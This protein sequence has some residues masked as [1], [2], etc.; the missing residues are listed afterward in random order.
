MEQEPR[1]INF[2]FIGFGHVGR[3]FA[4]L[5]ID[6]KK[7]LLKEYGIDWKITGIATRNHGTAIDHGGLPI[8]KILGSWKRHSNLDNF[9]NGPTCDSPSDFIRQCGADVL[10]EMSVLDLSGEPAA[11]FMRE[12]LGAGLHVITVNKGPVSLQFRQL[13][14]LARLR[15]VR[16]LYEGTVMDGAPVFN[17]LRQTLPGTRIRSLRGILNSTTN[18]ILTQ[19][20][21]GTSFEE[22]LEYT[23]NAG[24]AEADTSL[25]LEG[26]DSAAKLSILIQATMGG[27]VKPKDIERS[28][29]N[30]DTG[31]FVRAAVRRDRRL[32]LVARAYRQGGRVVG[33]V[34]LQELEIFDPLAAI[35]G[36]SNILVLNTDTMREL[37]IVENHPTVDQTAFGLFSDLISLLQ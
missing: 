9:H 23:R 15:G 12:A 32:R 30:E 29:I 20:E 10:F 28:S 26:W 33:K 2:A 14:R 36:L 16:F 1:Q 22:A 21:Q 17:M 6:R 35:R 18:Y 25:D 7:W 27:R 37:A 5:L 34:E 11:T 19:M 3:A 8:R 13:T 4:R 31:R 24:I